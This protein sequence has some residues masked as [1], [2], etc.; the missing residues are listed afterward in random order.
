[1]PVPTGVVEGMKLLVG[2][3][4]LPFSADV[5]IKLSFHQLKSIKIVRA[6]NSYIFTLLDDKR[7]TA[8]LRGVLPMG[9]LAVRYMKGSGNG[10]FMGERCLQGNRWFS[11]P[12]RMT[13][14]RVSDFENGEQSVHR[15]DG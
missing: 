11:P 3:L 6:V 15:R 10:S 12:A 8:S 14:S 4:K 5:S 13:S 7:T 9:T 1:M 2:G